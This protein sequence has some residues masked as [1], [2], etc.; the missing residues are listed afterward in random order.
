VGFVAVAISILIG[1][2]VGYEAHPA[3]MI[4]AIALGY[5]VLGA[6][7]IAREDNLGCGRGPSSAISWFF[8]R[9]EEGIVL[10]D[11]CLPHPTFFRYCDELL[12]RYR[13]DERIMNIAGTDWQFGRRRLRYSYWFSMFNITGWGWASW[14]RA[15]RPTGLCGWPAWETGWLEEGRGSAAA[16]VSAAFD[17]A[18]LPGPG[19]LDYRW[20]F[21]RWAQAAVGTPED[22]WFE[23]RLAERYPFAAPAAPDSAA[24]SYPRAP[25]VTVQDQR[26]TA[27]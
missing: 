2:L 13:D 6:S 17:R 5:L 4:L 10:E 24:C 14:R 15:Q 21:T 3:Y 1:V 8:E 27:S 26:L 7:V 20:M 23:H 19:L 12:E 9:V 11:D 18:H 22:H 25:A 16:G